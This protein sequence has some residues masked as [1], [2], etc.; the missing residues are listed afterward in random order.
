LIESR[1]DRIDKLNKMISSA[2]RTRNKSLQFQAI[3]EVK[4]EAEKDKEYS[5]MVE[6]A[7]INQGIL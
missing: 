4:K 7:L 6:S 1:K 3:A 5:A 2:F